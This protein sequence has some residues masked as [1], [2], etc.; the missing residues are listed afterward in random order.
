M[1]SKEAR[2]YFWKTC[3]TKEVEY[4]WKVCDIEYNRNRDILYDSD[5]SAIFWEFVDNKIRNYNPKKHKFHM[6]VGISVK[7]IIKNEKRRCANRSK[8]Y[9]G[10]YKEINENATQLTFIIDEDDAL[11][12]KSRPISETSPSWIYYDESKL[13]FPRAPS[14]VASMIREEIKKQNPDIMRIGWIKSLKIKDLD[15][16]RFIR[17]VKIIEKKRKRSK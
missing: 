5:A 2:Q 17:N 10:Y 14:F 15:Q 16:K 8:I 12:V 9:N 4:A 6:F 3:S 1:T 13:D 7:S 11:S